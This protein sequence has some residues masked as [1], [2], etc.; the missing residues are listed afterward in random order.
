MSDF[1]ENFLTDKTQNTGKN[2]T[3]GIGYAG[4]ALQFGTDLVK[5]LMNQKA[6][7]AAANSMYANEGIL[8]RQAQTVFDTGMENLLRAQDN[9]NKATGSAVT[10]RGGSGITAEGTGSA[11]ELSLLERM[12]SEMSDIGYQARSEQK[13][14]NYQADMMNYQARATKKAGRFDVLGTTLGVAGSVVGGVLG[15]GPLGASVGYNL[16]KTAGSGIRTLG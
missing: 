4:T 15:G 9:G 16:G 14:L 1:F 2:G 7:N 12:R 3:S 11:G 10:A 13:R 5:G 6:S 8:R